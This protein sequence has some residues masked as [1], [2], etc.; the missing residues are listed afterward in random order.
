MPGMTGPIGLANSVLK[1]GVAGRN[2][3]K[4]WVALEE[5]R[6]ERYP[7]LDRTFLLVRLFGASPLPD[8]YNERMKQRFDGK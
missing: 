4:E 3:F 7:H 1:F 5:A 8:E 6:V 2:D